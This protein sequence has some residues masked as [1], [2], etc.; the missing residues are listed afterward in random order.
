MLLRRYDTT[1]CLQHKSST[2][3]EH[4]AHEFPFDDSVGDSLNLT[5][6]TGVVEYVTVQSLDISTNNY[7]DA[8]EDPNSVP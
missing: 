1:H 4:N 5:V 8:T 3:A 7:D 2:D 6:R